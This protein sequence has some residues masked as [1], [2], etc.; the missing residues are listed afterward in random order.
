MTR[1]GHQYLTAQNQTA[2]ISYDRV[3]EYLVMYNNNAVPLYVRL[4]SPEIPNELNY[5]ISV[6]PNYIMCISVNS[7][8]FG[9]RL[10]MSVGSN[11][12]ITGTSVIEGM[13]D[14]A[15]PALGGVPIQAASLATA[16]LSNGFQP[17]SSPGFIGTF[18]LT[19]WG[20]LNVF[21]SPDAGSGQGVLFVQVS[22][23]NITYKDYGTWAFWPGVPFTINIPRTAVWARVGVNATAIPGEPSISGQFNIRA[24]LSEIQDYAYNTFAQPITKTFSLPGVSAVQYMFVT[25]G[26]PAVSVGA[27]A[28]AGTGASAALQ[29][30]IEASADLVN[31]RQVTAREQRMSQGITLYRSVGQLDAFVRISFFQEVVGQTLNATAYFSI[32]TQADLAYILNTIQQSLGDTN[33]SSN[34]GQDIYHELDL[35]RTGGNTGNSSLATIVTLLTGISGFEN[36]ISGLSTTNLPFLAQL[37]HLAAMDSFLS[38][39]STLSANLSNLPTINTNQAGSKADLDILANAKS[40]VPV[41]RTGSFTIPV[42][43]WTA[44]SVP[45][46][47][48]NRIISITASAYNPVGV[49]SNGPIGVGIGTN[50]AMTQILYLLNPTEGTKS[51]S[52]PTIRYDGERSG[53]FTIPAGTTQIWIFQGVAATSATVTFTVEEAP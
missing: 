26:L 5:D 47:V 33:A 40:G 43:V 50:V 25:A 52:C 18:N 53:G 14:E 45:L 21:L 1:I 9:F 36:N 24:S 49:T 6:P 16:Q 32:P 28:T 29:F 27:I 15:P 22:S 38:N 19:N 10:G 41:P 11:S 30:L 39:I 37:S 13:I 8:Q 34:S 51:W 42:N 4:G 44:S 3:I 7:Q 12:L 20:G 35:I 48:G 2:T 17:F 23:D 46:N 31:W